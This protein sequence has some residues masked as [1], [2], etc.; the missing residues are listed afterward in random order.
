MNKRQAK[1]EAFEN[2]RSIGE[3]RSL[4]NAARQ[5]TG[6]SRLNKAL[7]VEQCLDILERALDG[8]DNA[9]VPKGSTYN[10]YRY[11]QGLSKD[12]ILVH[13][14]LRECAG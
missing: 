1:K 12:G 10:I 6:V 9:E 4:I 7:T 5:R 8:R 13:N 14:I 2:D 11:R 3:L